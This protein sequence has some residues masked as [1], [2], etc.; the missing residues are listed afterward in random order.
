MAKKLSKNQ[1]TVLIIG[2][3][4]A[5][6]LLYRWYTSRQA[7]SGTGTTQASDSNLNSTLTGLSAGPTTELNYYQ[8]SGQEMSAQP[9]TRQAYNGQ[10]QA[11]QQSSQSGS[12]GNGRGR[13]KRQSQGSTT[14]GQSSSYNPGGPMQAAPSGGTTGFISFTGSNGQLI[15]NVQ[16][17]LAYFKSSGT[18]AG[19]LVP[20]GTGPPPGKKAVT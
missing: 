1:K 18:N 2:A 11:N 12:T 15:T 17:F 7:A 20:G 14:T 10:Y 16:Q 19:Q 9:V 6:Y 3:V 5:A 13:R 4:V 8:T